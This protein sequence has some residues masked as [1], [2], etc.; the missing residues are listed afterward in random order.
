MQKSLNFI[1]TIM[2]SSWQTSKQSVIT[3]T[4][5]LRTDSRRTRMELKRPIRRIFLHLFK[6]GREYEL[7]MQHPT[8]SGT[9]SLQRQI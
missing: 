8:I 2:G 4:L 3:L 1:L 9:V 6:R 7:T 5:L